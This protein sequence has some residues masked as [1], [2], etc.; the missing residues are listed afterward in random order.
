MHNVRETKMATDAAAHRKFAT[1]QVSCK[2]SRRLRA[3]GAY[4]RFRTA[5][6]SVVWVEGWWRCCTRWY[7]P[8]EHD[9]HCNLW[10]VH[11]VSTDGAL[12]HGRFV[13]PLQCKV[14]SG[15]IQFVSI[16]YA[17]LQTF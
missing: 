17:L 14:S 3:I 8:G 9:G 13:I 2:S 15:E 12:L 4:V 11:R 7:W 10:F 16:C 5:S 6:G 1:K